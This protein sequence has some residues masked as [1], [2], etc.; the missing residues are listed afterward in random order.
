MTKAKRYKRRRAVDAPRLKPTNY[1]IREYPFVCRGRGRVFRSEPVMSPTTRPDE[2]L[3]KDVGAPLV[4]KIFL[5]EFEA[6]VLVKSSRRIQ[7]FH[8]P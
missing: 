1:I 8:G 2:L 6:M 5:G 4:A 7:A 3:F